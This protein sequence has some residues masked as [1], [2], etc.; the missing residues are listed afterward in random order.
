MK[1]RSKLRILLAL[2]LTGFLAFASIDKQWIFIDS[3]PLSV[4][5]YSRLP[6]NCSALNHSVWSAPFPTFS[7]STHKQ[8]PPCLFVFLP[9]TG[10]NVQDNYLHG[11]LDAIA[12]LDEIHIL[13]LN[14]VSTPF[15]VG[16]GNDLCAEEMN[17]SACI[18]AIHE[19]VVFGSRTSKLWNVPFEHSIEARLLHALQSLH[20]KHPLA[21]W[22]AFFTRESDT[23]FT[24]LYEKIIVGGHSQG[25]G[26]AAYLASRRR[27]KRVVLLS[28]PQDCC[29]EDSFLSLEW[30][31]SRSQLSLLYHKLEDSAN[32]IEGN[33][34]YLQVTVAAWFEADLIINR[35]V[36]VFVSTLPPSSSCAGFPRSFHASTAV[37][38]CLPA[39]ANGN[40]NAY[41]DLFQYIVD[42]E[43]FNAQHPPLSSIS[44]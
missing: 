15:S 3:P 14:P 17:G 10:S 37:D 22:D 28:G 24:I 42:P 4:C 44:V 12:D 21:G 20:A 29:S 39:S 32:I 7:P 40:E 33:L 19:S 34:P 2:C 11:I 9:G 26:H 1:T 41:H 36:T 27:L 31:T 35:E 38:A 18:D 16:Q 8:S 13:G 30:Y 5:P 43:L 23:S 25:A 6:Y